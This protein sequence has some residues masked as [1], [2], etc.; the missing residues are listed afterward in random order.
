METP[1]RDHIIATPLW[2]LPIRFT[3]ILLA[4]VIF[5]LSAAVLG[6]VGA[7]LDAV[8]LALTVVSTRTPSNHK[9]NVA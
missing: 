1:T 3:Q 4:I 6:L 8:A 5:A 2:L 7:D 9:T